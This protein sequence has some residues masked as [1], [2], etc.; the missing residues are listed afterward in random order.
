MLRSY[1]LTVCVRR[2][3][4]T[5]FTEAWQGWEEYK[6]LLERIKEADCVIKGLDKVVNIL[7]GVVEVKTRTGACTDS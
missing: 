5:K 2:K 3:V 6:P 1:K 4:H 7:Y